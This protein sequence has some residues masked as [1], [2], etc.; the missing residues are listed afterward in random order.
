M[1]R[2]LACAWIDPEG[3]VAHENAYTTAKI[4]TAVWDTHCRCLFG[5][6]SPPGAWK[7]EMRLD[8]RVLASAPLEVR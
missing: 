7:V 5:P 8:G 2:A 6:A 1:T 3:R 4:R